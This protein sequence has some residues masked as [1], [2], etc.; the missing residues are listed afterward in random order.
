MSLR[1]EEPW[2]QIY[3]ALDLLLYYILSKQLINSLYNI[4]NT[5][6]RWEN[7]PYTG[8]F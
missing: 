2:I 7:E 5:L 8:N 1:E 6:K 3:T 4:L